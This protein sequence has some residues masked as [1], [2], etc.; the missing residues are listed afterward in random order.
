MKKQL[1]F[2]LAG[3]IIT[4]FVLACSSKKSDQRT[5]SSGDPDAWPEMESYHMVM[6]EAYHPFADSKNLEPTKSLAENLAKESEKW[7]AAPLPDKMNTE[8]VKAKLESLKTDSRKL[9]DLVKSGA[10]DEQI[11]AA[12]AAL[13]D[14][15]H[16]IIEEWQYGREEKDEHH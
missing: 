16:E 1:T 11:G 5:T 8:D 6:A 2:T 12:L 14:R 15:F 13:H 10:G 3:L 7:A 9:A 4:F